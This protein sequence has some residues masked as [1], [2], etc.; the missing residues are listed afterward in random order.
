[1]PDAYDRIENIGDGPNRVNPTPPL[2]LGLL[3]LYCLVKLWFVAGVDLGKDEA[4][5]WYW[6]QHLDASYAL[7]PFAA[8][9]LAHFLHPG[10]EWFL[11]LG[12][13]CSGAFSIVL[14]YRLCRLYHLDCTASL[15]A[16]IAF[17][18]SHWIWH[19][20]SYL[21]PDAFLVCC[22]LLTLVWA[23]QAADDPAPS[24]FIKVGVTAGLTCLCKYSAA[25]LVL[26]L[27]LWI[28]V[29]GPGRT[30]WA[31]L[32]Y[33]LLPCLLVATPLIYAQ[34]STAFYLPTTL[35]TLSRIVEL[36]SPPMRLLLF[37]LNPLL[38]VSPLL[39]WLLY[40][41]GIRV[42]LDLRRR[43]AE[44]QLLV[45]LPALCLLLG[46][47][48]FALFRGQIKGNWILPAFL[49]LWPLAF[50]RPCLPAN[51]RGF[52]VLLLATALLYTLPIAF[53][54]KYPGLATWLGNKKLDATYTA[55]VAQ[56][57]QAREQSFSW[58]ERLCEYSGWEVWATQLD[59][60][61]AQKGFSPAV[62]LLSAQYNIVF[63]L[64][65]YGNPQR[66]YFTVADPRFYNLTDFA[67]QAG[68]VY[69][70]DVLYAGRS[71]SS[72]PPSLQALY[73]SS[74]LVAVLPR[75]DKGCPPVNYQIFLLRQ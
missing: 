28:L 8:L 74:Q 3:A 12:W 59:T 22:W 64:A 29:G 47:A 46:F 24:S 68:P 34:F 72:L 60:S 36:Q 52:L 61:L 19:N 54:L 65:Y 41:A 37:L 30:R 62:P 45:F 33:A 70:R 39:L 14:L 17:A 15:W 5:Y 67:N 23:R 16:C 25:F 40:R 48:F 38:F 6:G 66:H 58:T 9:K 20:T 18:T 21:H 63:P 44:D 53:G 75:A 31:A 50:S 32:G 71:G 73:P 42:G 43:L 7:L 55:L 10:H 27:F 69:P 13:I 57:D 35:S 26:G 49:G 4:V 1:M 51:A 2:W 56:P 11:R